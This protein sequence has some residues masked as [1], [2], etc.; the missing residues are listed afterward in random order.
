MSCDP[1]FLTRVPL[2]SRLGAGELAILASHIEERHFDPRQRLYR[3]GDPGGRGYVLV[4]GRVRVTLIDDDQQEVTLEEP[5][6]GGFFGLASLLEGT[7]HQTGA[8]ALERTTCLE[9]DRDDL[10][11]LIA[12]MPDAGMD[13]LATLG[14]RLHAAQRLVQTRSLRNP[15]EV[16]ERE[17]TLGDRVADSV[18]RF[19]GS[20]RF[21]ILFTAVLAVYTAWNIV[22]GARAWDPYPFILLNLF[23]SMLA[24]IQAPVIM[25]SQNRKDAKDRLRGELDFQ[26]NRR[27]EAEIRGLGTKLND[28]NEQVADIVELLRKHQPGAAR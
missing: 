2:F 12:T 1:A 22:L 25:M 11:R 8:V 15:N 24:A 26:V 27:A 3:R 13:M 9:V 6:P 10:R 18:A 7:A 17:S 21:I 19:G 28:L 20:W 4:E 5:A 23:L 16:I 14:T